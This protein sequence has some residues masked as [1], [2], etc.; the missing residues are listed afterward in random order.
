M[1]IRGSVIGTKGSSRWANPFGPIFFSLG[2]FSLSLY[3]TSSSETLRKDSFFSGLLAF[4]FFLSSSLPQPSVH[5]PLHR[6]PQNDI[7]W[8]WYLAGLIDSVGFLSDVSQGP[9]PEGHNLTIAFHIKDIHLAYKIRSFLSFGTVSKVKNKNSCVYVLTHPIGFIFLLKILE[10]KLQH[11]LKQQRYF[12]LCAHFGLRPIHSF[13]S[14]LVFPGLF[15][16]S[17]NTH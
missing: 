2:I 6:Y 5:R 11:K 7:E 15:G 3:N 1:G 9:P 14:P 13:S 17:P 10:N 8:G 4:C 12:L 16:L